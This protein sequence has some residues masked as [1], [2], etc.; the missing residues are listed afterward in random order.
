MYDFTDEE[1]TTELLP[2]R[3]ALSFWGMNVANVSATNVALAQNAATY[4]S[5][6]YAAAGQSITVYQG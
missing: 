1:L 2:S 5:S 3:E 6:A 4:W